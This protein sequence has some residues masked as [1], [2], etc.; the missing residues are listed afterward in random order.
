MGTL[1]AKGGF[2][3]VISPVMVMAILLLLLRQPIPSVEGHGYLATPRSRNVYAQEET[4]WIGNWNENDPMP[5]NCMQCLAGKSSGG[6]GITGQ[7][8]YDL[9][10]N[11]LGGT[12]KA[13]T[14]ATYAVG[15]EIMVD[16]VL[17]AHHKGHFVFS[18]CPISHGEIPSQECFDE[19]QL[20]FVEDMI[21]GANYDPSYPERA[22]VAPSEYPNTNQYYSFKMRLPSSLSGDLVLIQW[23][24]L[25]ANSC[26]HK[27]YLEYNWPNSWDY[28]LEGMDRCIDELGAEKFW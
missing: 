15:Q 9:P 23:Y 18:G 1:A 6:C 7:N 2:L 5:E 22:Y 11:A 13:N 26:I 27:G 21:H 17:T 14:Q 4:N 16:V 10:K 28:D 25:T 12:M 24:Y 19:H 8:N 20:T 3:C